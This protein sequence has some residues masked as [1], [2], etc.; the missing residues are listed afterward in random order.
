MSALIIIVIII[1][2]NIYCALTMCQALCAKYF[3]C[4]IS[5]N[6]YSTL[7]GGYYYYPLLQI[8][9]TVRITAVIMIAILSSATKPSM[10]QI[11]KSCLFKSSV[12]KNRRGLR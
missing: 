12:D 5:F 7:G 3:M 8:E 11:L 1:L 9:I 2:G 6:P 4:K 10:Q